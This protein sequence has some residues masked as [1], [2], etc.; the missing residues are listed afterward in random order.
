M[1]QR[2]WKDI[3]ELIGI[4]AIVA[5]L[6]FV[7]LQ[8]KQSQ[9]IALAASFQARTTTLAEA[10]SARA[11]NTEALAA[12]LRVQGINPLDQVTG[13]SIDIP[14]SAGILTELEY[15]AG[16]MHAL[17][18]WQQ[19][20]N[21]YYQNEMG[22]MPDGSWLRLRSAIKANFKRK[23]LASLVYDFFEWPPGFQREI[24]KIIAEVEAEESL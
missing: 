3:A 22:F 16:I 5:S 2:H 20:N 6:I 1:A 11:A 4:I 13:L 15:R 23:T 17:S 8:M 19:W 24:D 12:E 18:M 14:E 9:D 21:I 10:F 7:G